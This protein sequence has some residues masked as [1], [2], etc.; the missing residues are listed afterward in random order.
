VAA[1]IAAILVLV[2]GFVLVVLPSI[3]HYKEQVWDR[4]PFAV[5]LVT[6]KV[7]KSSTPEATTTPA[8]TKVTRTVT[9][10]ATGRTT[11]TVTETTAATTQRGAA[12]TETTTTTKEASD[13]LLER[14]LSTGGL[15]LFRVAIVAFAAFIAGAVV[16]RAILGKYALKLGV[17][18]LGELQEGTDT[19]VT[20]LQTAVKELGDTVKTLGETAKTLGDKTNALGETTNALVDQEKTLSR[21]VAQQAAA[22]K[23]AIKALSD[24][25]E[26]LRKRLPPEPARP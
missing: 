1:L 20:A 6:E 22:S 17:L 3:T 21:R 13:S 16:Q 11:T 19:A 24:Q 18:E 9:R 12:T 25:V 14:A 2:A 23:K 10:G 26:E 5:R 8:T 15:V 4:D 7:T